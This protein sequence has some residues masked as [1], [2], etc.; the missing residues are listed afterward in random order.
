MNHISNYRTFESFS[1]K[2]VLGQKMVYCHDCQHSFDV[3]KNNSRS[4]ICPQCA[5]MGF[6]MLDQAYLKPISRKF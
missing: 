2:N 4:I 1:M 3:P 6:V 5:K